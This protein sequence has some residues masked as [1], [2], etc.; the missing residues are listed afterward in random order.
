MKISH[1]ISAGL[2]ALSVFTTGCAV[3]ADGAEPTVAQQTEAV[4]ALRVAGKGEGCGL[5]IACE[6]GLVCQSNCPRGALCFVSI[7]T[8]QEPVKVLHQGEICSFNNKSLGECAP[9][10][11]CESTCP[12]G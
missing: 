6:P 8:C 4:D 11:V 12:R 3:G 7:F 2:F 9:G 1:V 5:H 10:L